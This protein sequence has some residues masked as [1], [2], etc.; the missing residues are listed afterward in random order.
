MIQIFTAE[1]LTDDLV[2]KMVVA[3]E[4]EDNH[5][6]YILPNP[7]QKVDVSKMP[8]VKPEMIPYYKYSIKGIRRYR[9]KYTKTKNG[10]CFDSDGNSCY[11]GAHGITSI[12]LRISVGKIS[13]FI[14]R[15]DD[16]MT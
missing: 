11:A 8:T 16:I 2:G 4:A 5:H 15:W 1:E 3:V 12:Q 6:D 10:W 14:L 7:L 9:T 13:N